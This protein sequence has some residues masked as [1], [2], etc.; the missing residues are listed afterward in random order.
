MDKKNDTW[1][2]KSG[3]FNLEPL[4][5]R[6]RRQTT[7]DEMR[8]G[9]RDGG[10]GP[11]LG[12]TTICVRIMEGH[13]FQL[14]AAYTGRVWPDASHAGFG[15]EEPSRLVLIS[16]NS[17]GRHRELGANWP[18]KTHVIYVLFVNTCYRGAVKTRESSSRASALLVNL[19]LP[20]PVDGQLIQAVTIATATASH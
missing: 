20:K 14:E 16:D 18:T 3:V 13:L 9:K 7:R 15:R 5:S 6:R 8:G 10:T 4:W 19:N 11:Y 2:A 1:K 12:R 17:I